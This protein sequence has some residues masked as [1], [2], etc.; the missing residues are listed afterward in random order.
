[1]IVF[2]Q[3]PILLNQAGMQLGRQFKAPEDVTIAAVDIT[4]LLCVVVYT[5]YTGFDVE[6][7]IASWS[8]HWCTKGFLR[9]AFGYPF[10]QLK[11]DRVSGR[12]TASNQKAIDMDER[13]GFKREGLIR[14]GVAGEDVIIF[15][16]LREECR[17]T[18]KAHGQEV[19]TKSAK[20]A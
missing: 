19:S 17:W 5:N 7:C 18:G 9:L 10:T 13:L 20:S 15:G 6:M 3:H 8:P 14:R 1:M 2:Q 16:M 12:V 4:K 11:C